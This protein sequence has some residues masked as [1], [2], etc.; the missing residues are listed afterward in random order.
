[1]RGISVSQNLMTGLLC[2]FFKE[3]KFTHWV[4]D[5]CPFI[6]FVEVQL[7]LLFYY[8]HVSGSITD[9]EVIN[10]ESTVDCEVQAFNNIIDFYGE[11]SN[12]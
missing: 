8:V 12:G 2:I 1:M 10:V 5:C 11:E 3:Q 9:D 6:Y 7:Q 4:L